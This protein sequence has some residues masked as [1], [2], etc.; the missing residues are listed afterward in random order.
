MKTLV[1]RK[2]NELLL[3]LNDKI[4]VSLEAFYEKFLKDSNDIDVILIGFNCIFSAN[5]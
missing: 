5:L 1:E 4:F 3:T 2:G